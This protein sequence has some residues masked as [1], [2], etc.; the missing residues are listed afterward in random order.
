MRDHLDSVSPRLRRPLKCTFVRINITICN[1]G[2]STDRGRPTCASL[3]D[4]SLLP[5]ATPAACAAAARSVPY[6]T[7]PVRSPANA[8]KTA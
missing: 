4:T 8:N 3:R 5:T 6:S 2:C 1:T 7:S